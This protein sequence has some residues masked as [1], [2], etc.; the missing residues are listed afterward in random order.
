MGGISIWHMIIWGLW[1]A[2][3]LIL[4][5]AL[6]RFGFSPAWALVSVIPLAGLV[7]LWIIAFVRWPIPDSKELMSRGDD[8]ADTFG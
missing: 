3:I 5:R 2:Q 7:A 8:L 4:M 6:S 1:I